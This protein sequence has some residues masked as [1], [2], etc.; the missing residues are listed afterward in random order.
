MSVRLAVMALAAM[1]LTL[2][3]LLIAPQRPPLMVA[4][5]ILLGA[6]LW[7]V[8]GLDTWRRRPG[9]PL[10]K[11]MA[12]VGVAQLLYVA[13]WWTTSPVG[14]VVYGLAHGLDV[15][16][17][18]HLV[19]AFP[20]GRLQARIDRIVIGGAYVA[21][22]VIG[23]LGGLLFWDSTDGCAECARNPLLIWASGTLE[24]LTGHTALAL[25]VAAGLAVLVRLGQRWTAATA[26][27]RR[28]LGPLVVTGT[29]A[30]ALA[31]VY[32]VL[33]V[34]A[35]SSPLTEAVGWTFAAFE[36]LV[37]IA[38]AV[39]L[40]R[41]RLRRTAIAGLMR[42]L[43]ASPGPED[44]RDA[45]ARALGD[46]S[47]ELLSWD[48]ERGAY[49]DAAGE[50]IGPN[51]RRA[52][53]PLRDELGALAHDPYILDDPELI[54]GV[55]AAARLAIQNGHL[56]AEL[57]AR[58]AEVRASR[59]RIVAAAD[60]ERRRLERD[61]HD[62]AQQRLLGIRLA[63]RLARGRLPIDVQ[64]ADKLLTEADTELVA[65]LE[66]LRAL[67]RGIH[68]AVLTDE[69]L[70]AALGSLARRATLPVTIAEVPADRL[71]PAVEAAAYFVASE[72]LANVTKHAH[73]RTATIAMTRANGHLQIEISDDGIGGANARDGGGLSGLRDR[74]GALE[75]HF[76]LDTAP[77]AGTTLRADIPV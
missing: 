53:T 40:L 17:L 20:Q 51:D 55:A 54:D 36:A 19:L 62:G 3:L 10:A 69:G 21:V 15:V 26:V 50:P 22:V 66:E 56:G 48:P 33:A 39:G 63:L 31:L 35:T 60:I 34:A 67:A 58:L 13:G 45:L 64:A 59:A 72:A 57:R 12:L 5:T 1:V 70:A 18:G 41:A 68:P 29:A 28:V 30:C 25:G 37:P 75:G 73:A 38:F 44:V 47:L 24:S 43:A 2:V 32:A 23:G 52:L 14:V 74:V 6:G 4:V 49:V 27:G 61:L 65:T 71:P 76:E 9:V 46:T 42:D 77:G 8:I 11:L 7:L 16:I